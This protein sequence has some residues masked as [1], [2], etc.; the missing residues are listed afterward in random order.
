MQANG[1]K[2][3]KVAASLTPFAL[4][5]AVTGGIGGYIVG[6]LLQS[7]AIGLFKSYWMLPT[8]FV[9]FS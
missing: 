8:S 2:K 1:I 9:A 3:Y 4:I 7:A 5:P 6:T